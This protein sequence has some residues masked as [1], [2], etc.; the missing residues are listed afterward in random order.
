LVSASSAVTSYDPKGMSPTINARFAPRAT[1][2]KWCM[3]R[4]KREPYK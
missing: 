1:A 2:C 3:C 4:V